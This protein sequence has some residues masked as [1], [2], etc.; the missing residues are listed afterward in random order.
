VFTSLL[1]AFSILITPIAA[2]AQ[3]Q[4]SGVRSQGPAKSRSTSEQPAKAAAKDVFVNP[5]APAPPIGTVTAT[6][7]GTI[8]T[9]VDSDTKAD[10]GVD[11]ITYTT[12]ITNNTGADISGLQFTDTVDPHTTIIAGSAV[13][14]GDD[15]YSTIGNVNINV[16]LGTGVLANDFN[17]NTGNNTGITVSSYG[18]TTGLEQTSVGTATPTAQGG[19]V[20]VQSDGSFTFD[21]KVGFSGTD[22]FRYA[23][24]QS[25]SKA[26][27][28]VRITVTGMI[29][30]V[31][32]DAPSCLTIS[33]PCGTLAHPF[34]TLAAFQ[35]VNDAGAGPPL[36]PKDNDNIFIYTGV[37]NYTGGVTLRNGQKLI[38]QGATASIET[39]TSL[40]TPSGNTVLPAT[41]GTNPV[42]TTGSTTDNIRLGTGNSNLIRGFT[43]GDSGTAT[44][45]SADI[46]GTSIG[47]LTV[48]EVTLNG[49][50]Q[51]LKI[52]GGALSGSF[53]S[54]TSTAST[55][56]GMTLGP[57]AVTGSINMGS[58]TIS[59]FSLGCITVSNTTANVTF[60]NTSCTLGGNEGVNLSNNTA[61][62]R[63]FGSLTVSG[64]SGTAFIHGS[65][66]GDVNITGAASFT[67][68][69][70]D[71]SVS[72]PANG[73]LIDFQGATSAT[74][75]GSNVTAVNWAGAAGATMQFSSLAIQRKNG[76]ALNASGGGTITINN[77]GSAS[78]IT[79]TTDGGPAIVA[80]G[81]ALG[82]TF[83]SINSS[84]SSPTGTSAV[85]LT[86]VTGTSNFG[87]GALS[88]SSGA[89]FLVS[90]GTESV[91]YNGTIGQA[92][93]APAVSITGHATGTFTFGGN[94]TGSVDGAD[95]FFD[96]ADGTYNFNATNAFTN[97]AGINITN[98]SGGAFSF[99]GN[100]SVT[101]GLVGANN[102]CFTANGSTAGVTYS[103][104]LTKS[105]TSAG[106]LVDVT[107]EAS[108]TITFQTGT[109]SSTSSS[110]TS[111]GININNAD[112]TVNFNGTN[113]LTGGNAH[114]LIANGSA[115]TFNF[116]SSSTI[117]SPSSSPAFDVSGTPANPTVTYSGNITQNT[118]GQR[119]VNIDSTTGNTIT[120]NTG[121]ITGGAS[122]TGINI[123][124]A[125]GN[126][127]FSNGMTL[128]TSGSPMT[129]QA[130]TIT[131]GTGTYSLGAVSIFTNNVSGLVATNADGTINSTSGTVNSSNATAINI[132]GPAG[133]TTLGMTLTK[134][135]SAGGTADG[136]SIQDTGGTFTVNGDGS[137]TTLGGNASGGTISNKSGA[138]G[139][140][141]QGVGVFLSNTTG[142]TLRRMTINGTNQ[143]FGVRG[144]N[145]TNFTMEYSTVSGTNGTN[146][147]GGFEESSV[148]FDGLFTSAAITSCLIE[149]GFADNLRVSNT[150]G[151]LNRLVV[152]GCSFGFN[153]TTVGNNSVLLESANS[154][155]VF[156]ATINSSTFK[157]AHAD[158]INAGPITG[159]SMDMII[160]TGGANTFDNTGANAHPTAL[161]A[162][163][164]IVVS[165]A[166]GT[167]TYKIQNNTLKGSK[168]S[169]IFARSS[170]V[171]G[172]GGAEGSM[173][174][175]I[176][177]NTIGVAAIANSGSSEASG[178]D[179]EADGGGDHTCLID[180]NS[181]FQYN[182]SGITFI[183]GDNTAGSVPPIPARTVVVQ[184]TV[185]NNTVSN[186][187]NLNTN[188][189]AIHLN[190]G[191]TSEDGSTTADDD[192]FTSCIDVHG[193]H[194]IGGGQGTT[195]PNNQDM[196]FQERIRTTV[197]LPGYV[198]ANNDNAAV[199]TFEANQNNAGG[200][201]SVAASNTV[202]TGGGGFVGGAACTQP[203][204]MN[205]Q[206]ERLK[207]QLFAR[208]DSAKEK[209][210]ES[211]LEAPG[212]LLALV[213]NANV[214]SNVLG[215]NQAAP[216]AASSEAVLRLDERIPVVG[217]Q[218]IIAT[219]APQAEIGAVQPEVSL[220]ANARNSLFRFAN[221]I[222]GMIEPTAHAEEIR[223]SKVGSQRSEVRTQTSGIRSQRSDV[224]LNHA[225]ST[226]VV[227]RNSR[228]SM[229]MAPFA[230]CSPAGI[231]GGGTA[232]CVDLPTIHNGESITISFQV[233][234]NNPPNLTGVPPGVAQVSNFG[235]VTG[236]CPNCPVTTNTVNTPVDLFDTTTTLGSTPNPSDQGNQ[237]T[238][239]ATVAETPTQASAD[240]TGTVNF[241]DTSN[242]NAVV[243]GNVPLVSGSAQCLTSSL[244]ASTHN[245]R[246][247]YSGDGNFDP[248]QSNVV[249]QVVNACG[250]N[251]V[252]TNTLDSGAGSL[253]DAITNIC[254]SPNNN[255]TFNI[256]AGDGGHV[257]GVYTITLTTGQIPIAK[258]VN[259]TGPNT[260]SNTDP[261]TINGNAAGRVFKVNSGITAVI[262]TLTM[263]NGLVSG[264]SP[265]GAGGAIYNDHGTLT[266]KNST[267]SGST[268]N[269]GGGIF[270]DG[271][272][273]GSATLNIINSTISGNTANADGGAIHN[274]GVG[275]GNATLFITNSTISG[276]LAKFSG[277]G[278]VSDGTGGIASVTITNSTITNNRSDSDTN[279][280][281]DGGGLAI[282]GGSAVIL[283]NS[284]VALN[285][286]GGSP[287][288]TASDI[289][290]AL[291]AAHSTHNDVGDCNSCGLTNGVS[292]NTLG[293]TGAQ[294]NLGALGNNGGPV[295]THALLA[296]SIAIEAGN[297]VYVV[298]PPFLNT[299]PI[300][301][302]RGTGFPRIADSADADTTA[303]VDIGA[304]EAHPTVEDITDKTTAEDTAIP[305]FSFNI[306]DGT[307]A[308]ITSVTATSGNTTLI[309]NANI[310]VGGSGS[311]RTLDISPAA[312][313]NSPSDGTATITVTVTATNGRTATDTFV[314][315]VTEVNDA[316]VPSSD[317]IGAID[318]DCGA[319]CSGGKY[320]IPFA[321]LLA[322]DTNKGAA[323]ESGQTLNITSVS[324]PTGGTVAINGTNVEFTP[325]A[326]FNGPAGFT[327]TV[328]D[329]GTTNTAPDPK[330]GSAT[331]SFTINAVNDP[332]SF[333]KGAD[334][335][336]NEDAGAQSVSNWATAISPGPA[337][338][339]LQTVSFN[340]TGN[341]NS[342]LFSVQPAVSPSGTLTYTPAANA[343]GTATITLTAQDNAGGN[344]TSPP[345][346]FV[347]NVTAVADT[348]SVAPNPAT[349][350]EDTQTS[351]LVIS[352]NAN[353]STEVTNF[354]ITNIVHGTLFQNDGT[355][356]ISTG[357]FITFAQ[358]NAGLKFTP[359]ADYNNAISGPA[360]FD[361]QA[362]TASNDT[363]LGGAVVTE[364]INVTAVNDAPS[365][366]KGPDQNVI[367]NAG[368]QSVSNWATN[369]AKGP[370]TATDETGQT[371]TFNVTGNTN[372]SLFSAG[373]AVS[374]TGTLTYTPTAAAS[375]TATITLT[376]SDS[377]SNVSP[378]V[379]TSPSQTFTINV[380]QPTLSVLD[381]VRAEPAS[382]TANMLFTVVLNP[383][384]AA[385]T[386]TV[387]YATADQAPGAGHAA[388]GTC[389][390]PGVDYQPTSGT[391]TFNP[392]ETTKTI[393]VGICSDNVNEPDETFLMN[394][395]SPS[396]ATVSRA[397]ATGTIKQANLAG[398]FIISEIRTSG[399][400]GLG[401]DFVELYNNTDSPLTVAA[402]DASAGYGVFKMGT[403]CNATPVLIATIPNGTVIPARGHYLLVG[404]QYSLANYGGAGA[405]AGDQTLTSD[406]E[407]DRNV[408]V[409]NTADVNNL[410]TVTR[411]DGVGFGT[412]SDGVTTGVCDLLREGTN[413]PP[414]SGSNTEHSFFRKE[415]DYNGT[416]CNVNGTPKDTNDNNADFMFADT[417]GTFISGVPQA[418]GAPGP[419]NKTSGIQ[420]NSTIVMP[421]LD[422][423]LPA[424]AVPN[425]DRTFTPN[426]PMAPNGVLSI[427]RRIQNNTGGD[428]TALRFRVVDITTFPSPGGGQADLRA[429]T[430]SNTSISNVHDTTTCVDR[431]AGTASNC[432]VTVRGTTLETPPNQPN[433]G[434]FN[435]S[436]RVDL[437]GLPGNKLAANQSVEVQLA[438]GVVQGGHF[439][440]LVNVEDDV[441]GGD[442][443]KPGM[444]LASFTEE[445]AIGTEQTISFDPVANRTFGDGD[446]NVNAN[447]SS[448]LPV[449][450]AGTGNCAVSSAGGVHL[451]GAGACTITASQAGDSTHNPAT[452]QQVFTIG[453]GTPATSVT[454][455][456]KAA[457][458]T[459]NVTFTAT[460]APPANTTAAT[461]TVQ[462]KD[463]GVDL[464]P[465]VALDGNGQATFSTA[466]LTAGS[467]TITASYSGNSNF[468]ASSN[469]LAQAVT[470]RPLVNMAA[471][472]YEVKQ[473]DGFVRVLVNRGGDLS[474]PVTVDYATDGSGSG[475]CAA[476]RGVASLRCDVTAMYGTFRF[477]AGETQKTLDI[478]INQDSY[479][480]GPETFT[481][482]LSNATGPDALL[483]TPAAANI[484]IDDAASPTPNAIDD[485]T[486]FVR[487][488]YHDFLNREPDAAG[489]AFWKNNI[490]VCNT[491]ATEAARYG[492]VSACIETKRVTTSAAFF[493]SIEFRGTG[494]LVRD[495]YV[496]A[497]DRPASGNMPGF[498]EF[499]RDT[500][501]VQN[502]V[503]VGQT[504]WQRTLDANRA[505]FMTDFVMRP[506]FVGLYSTMDTPSQ[507]VDK[508]YSHAN[509]TPEAAE[510]NAAIAEFGGAT[511]ASDPGAR[512]RA[513]LRITQNAAF[514]GRELNRGFVQMQYFGYLRRNPNDEPDALNGFN[515]WLNK[516]NQFNG[517]YVS[518]E[519]VKAFL[520]SGEYRQRFG[521]P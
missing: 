396:G 437:T 159:S 410:S 43:V 367:I 184:M 154:G 100:T 363:G 163:N 22:T 458:L 411:L 9:D 176:T 155:T 427:R 245:I 443:S 77:T 475:N 401:D 274:Q 344:D 201:P 358:G 272:A 491:D 179:V 316:P 29:W 313:R 212:S 104:N 518:A 131:G 310:V 287:S 213:A 294:L 169:A 206:L 139:N 181:V 252:V 35:A 150:S 216:P 82:A 365:F 161:S 492:G 420:R 146:E 366:T 195:P 296:G 278:V 61:G 379:N 244:T 337:N 120:F 292:N 40:S 129:N 322:N 506:E 353:D 75:T 178:I 318:E 125:N 210:T 312:D 260:V 136:I 434:G 330:S 60:G 469:T 406:I 183:F 17:P 465:A 484:T 18:A 359:A 332:P 341:T 298:A 305:Q 283:R 439:R 392:G 482:T 297:N 8:T 113:T 432:T 490:D 474:V 47:T 109:L 325:T 11:T 63:T 227:T 117:T 171:T 273:S 399:P 464:G 291:D 505:A 198:G 50:G 76:I 128:G 419:Q 122:S 87:S 107:T 381:A 165:T 423:S 94:I 99:S 228:T 435:S 293:V 429:T 349:T 352:R 78:T 279:G 180:S 243:C 234:V 520:S 168:G 16:P 215:Y 488:Q 261:I 172:A 42:L 221:A 483:V 263:T 473:S 126:V 370:V 230:G 144:L 141:T 446:F 369:L 398:T 25:G 281:G 174:G 384:L 106:L 438:F 519:M 49:S 123:N 24:N 173:N 240:P 247:D 4:A 64:I 454:S 121:T 101:N 250:S 339:S 276:N 499:T 226:K 380:A 424:S 328:T 255:I 237:V 280:V 357:D 148:S 81:I 407:S 68:A 397:Q 233:T 479:T 388:S 102:A 409:F 105:G 326:D 196:R 416:G 440:V 209:A 333:T 119:V 86:N 253:R 372:P 167:M 114:V 265:G 6:M 286:K 299:T 452:T 220:A 242:G 375:G 143:N 71:I 177:G 504:D 259:I 377:G 329:D 430:S 111:N 56:G 361:V 314:V 431:T 284:I 500:Q 112:G 38:G 204:A 197:R 142:I 428:V 306:G 408:G 96:N 208:V 33:T 471:A 69:G 477:A 480:Q 311:S 282:F 335:T 257:G 462:F 133:L 36:H 235:T 19:S 7:T 200:T 502:G 218:P 415:C 495:F 41:S 449:S 317:A 238:F 151:T 12:T 309:P 52:N 132:D 368:A 224:R 153:G 489:L 503:V 256:P 83:N 44:G 72:A 271:S 211:R 57:N 376:L 138:D 395:T 275:G 360:G 468:N 393:K 436:L 191:T 166:T 103:G 194:V 248:S 170:G 470:N 350:N 79:N 92:N 354:K 91:T 14:A 444:T 202:S 456:L 108:G 391:L 362:S 373:P 53:T 269:P 414:V 239:T 355:T 290:G 21:P 223:T 460:V 463:N 67:T 231:N 110:A 421:L 149:G 324:S 346:S 266:I 487:Q 15:A 2:M 303:T 304:Y 459:Q 222:A 84:A 374:N 521:T 98:G 347:I 48:S 455:S 225:R 30:F 37:G 498:V 32:N 156:N 31:K 54:V 264:A 356:P 137:N 236:T 472:N 214:F 55:G 402:S 426:P 386:V 258:N 1:L 295:Q 160:G 124:A 343:F 140:N 496:A 301:D 262:D 348:P 481:V 70:N 331:V 162:G 23:S 371:L 422:S 118:S 277:G 93:A 507:Y 445:V 39:I 300:T 251:P 288:T 442:P 66:G 516:L 147:A 58:T 88:G 461:G 448:G 387:N 320:V 203:I 219:P 27:A 127:T 157:G 134:V 511:S 340:I 45:D 268:A 394:L 319:G 115:G 378:N 193:N 467:H 51:T 232:I 497:L 513:L 323:N 336:V 28:T 182:N 199:Q 451:T 307:G 404:S 383:Q 466:S 478:P 509:A 241:I 80:N 285:F 342:A 510:R 254:A 515:F 65:A 34:S 425:R 192:Q 189:N 185:T 476:L 512:G 73:D 13:A 390:N 5:P 334:Q 514:Q 62:L 517:D 413:L 175:R 321:T 188:F 205:Q 10:P 308:L 412:N 385:Q 508:L 164:R 433:G 400:A 364:V 246:A 95:L 405:A 20:T 417:Q 315:T 267:V 486:I 46:S 450:Y 130:L 89:T 327:Y 345:Q 74:T 302:A 116:S 493:L 90:G 59:G 441:V 145:V 97:G 382:G 418:L 338:E 389:G 453:K 187:G 494:G 158:W 485:S 190:N 447:A 186:P 457:K 270:N 289:F 26:I 501:A 217:P 229:A 351:A 152:T 403:N 3:R 85:S 207:Q 249:A 135:D